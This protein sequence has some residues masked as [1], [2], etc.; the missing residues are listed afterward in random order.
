MRRRKRVVKV[1]AQNR[2]VLAKKY[3][4]NTCEQN[5][6]FRMVRSGKFTIDSAAKYVL[7]DRK[8]TEVYN[9]RI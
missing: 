7:S 4:L 8:L 1:I 6:V 2:K 3:G 5:Q 9:E